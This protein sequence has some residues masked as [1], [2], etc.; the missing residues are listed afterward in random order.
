MGRRKIIK[1]NFNTVCTTLTQIFD[2]SIDKAY[3]TGSSNMEQQWFGSLIPKEIFEKILHL[4]GKP[5]LLELE[6]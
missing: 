3:H 2:R 5:S 1:E 4:Y 6:K